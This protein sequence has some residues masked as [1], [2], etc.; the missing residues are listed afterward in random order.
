LGARIASAGGILSD[1]NLW[2][3]WSAEVQE[4]PWEDPVAAAQVAAGAAKL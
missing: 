2:K 4:V 3:Y 1:E